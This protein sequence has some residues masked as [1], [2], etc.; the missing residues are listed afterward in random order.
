MDVRRRCGSWI[1]SAEGHHR[2][3]LYFLTAA[4]LFA[5]YLLRIYPKRSQHALRREN[6]PD[7]EKPASR[8]GSSSKAPERA[9]GVWTPVEFKRPPAPPYPD[10]DVHTAEPIP[11]RP[12]RHGPYHITMGLRT[13]KWDEWIE[14][15]NQY[16]RFHADKARRIT[17][18]GSKCC[19]TAP[20]AFDGAVELLEELTDYLPQRYPSLYTRTPTGIHN[21]LTHETF[22]V[23][24]RPL[25][26]DPM[27]TAAR[28]V[29]DDLAIMFEKPDGQ[30]Y[31]LAGAILL[32]G[33]WRL[34]DKFGMPLS[35]IH[36]SGDVPGFKAKLEKGMMNF[37]RRVQPGQPV[38]RNNYFI[39]VDDDL[40]W[41][42]SI[43]P[44]DQDVD[45]MGSVR[46]AGG[47]NTAE[48]NK[49]IEHHYFRTER[50][51]LRRLPRSGGVVF[52]IR[53]Y[54]EPITKVSR[55]W[56]VPGRLA[57][58]VR[59]WGEDVSRYKGRER[60]GEVLL[61]Y[62]DARHKEQVA[63]GLKEGEE[64]EGKSYPF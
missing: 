60:Y 31:L 34:E 45:E 47:W 62:L 28:L 19:R 50:Q 6:S 32:P 16:L 36:T 51:S 40:A 17:E 8:R 11:Y 21:L 42:H 41:S 12:F 20:E 44:E 10:W 2:A 64:V 38:L 4:S 55:E 15:D 61:E 23:T 54:F 43:G 48:K 5:W 57:S 35:E 63:Q 27:Q 30:Y 56:G 39:Q 52:T 49:A 53:T 26:E 1:Q 37:F 9:P 3:I 29:Q 59:S 33:F 25:P 58:A 7:L 46:K 22:D 18:R 13:M 14:L 24:Q